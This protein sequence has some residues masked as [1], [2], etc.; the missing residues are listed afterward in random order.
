MKM[1][2]GMQIQE[3]ECGNGWYK[4][5]YLKRISLH[6]SF[7]DQHMQCGKKKAKA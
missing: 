4:K 5:M 3:D 7:I 2:G 1:K 6:V